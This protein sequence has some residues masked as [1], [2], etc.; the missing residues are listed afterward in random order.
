ML[1]ASDLDRTLI[2]SKRFLDKYKKRPLLIE[3]KDDKEISFIT[4][5]SISILK[6]IANRIL[7]IPVTTR[8]I[9]QYKRISFLKNTIIPKYAIVSNGGNILV[10]GKIDSYWA[11]IISLKLKSEC[12]STKKVLERFGE[13]KNN[14]WVYKQMKA[15]N[16]FYYYIIDKDNIPLDEI[17]D[18]KKWLLKHGW[19]ISIQ[20]RKL[21]LIP[22]FINKLSAVKYIKNK[23]QK[24]K[25]IASGDSLLDLSMLEHADIAFCPSHG[26]IYNSYKEGYLKVP[27]HIVFTDNQGMS[28]S[29]E[30]LKEV[31]RLTC[32]DKLIS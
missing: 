11:K 29:E 27:K 30:I 1:F 21:Y 3:T 32:D 20:G 9:E 17:A 2:Y 25:V 23:T 26:E 8:T 4:E 14:D 22:G 12:I 19:N 15:D 10:N 7:F 5:L 13:I 16:L 6:K 24:K 18:F 31:E 28:A